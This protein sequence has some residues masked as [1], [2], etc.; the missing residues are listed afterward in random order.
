MTMETGAQPMLNDAELSRVIAR[1]AGARLL[2]LRESFGV[3]DPEDR[4]R[5]DRLRKEGDREAQN[6][7][8]AALAELAAARK[9][10]AEADAQIPPL[11]GSEEDTAAGDGKGTEAGS[12]A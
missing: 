4:D 5:A 12:D 1:E 6:L 10:Q 3:M 9:A 2:E 11:P 8:A 7:I